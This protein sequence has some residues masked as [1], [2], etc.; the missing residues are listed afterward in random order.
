MKRLK[1]RPIVVVSLFL[2]IVLAISL[3]SISI[4]KYVT[5]IRNQS[6]IK[7]EDFVIETNY[8]DGKTYEIFT[9]TVQVD[10]RNNR[11]TKISK[12][13]ITFDILIKN[14]NTSE[15]I[16]SY[17]N[18][19]LGGA[20]KS[21]KVFTF[22]NLEVN[23]NYQVIISST[24][25]IKKTI[26]HNFSIVSTIEVESYYT[27]TNY[28]SWI[29]LDIYIGTDVPSSLT[30]VYGNELSADNTNDLMKTWYG[31][32]G[33]LTSLTKNNHYKL[34]FFK[35]VDKTYDSVNNGEIIS[36]TITIS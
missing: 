14:I 24:S 22:D 15:V 11:L 5:D 12:K 27:L 2:L 6:L 23:T 9:D 1:H 36:N 33:L 17:N 20:T 32:S 28:E 31:T 34:I 3:I 29:E 8:L 13:D 4:A 25:P 21:N 10:V 26:T 35:T 7:L 16:A 30:I 19:T 18:Q